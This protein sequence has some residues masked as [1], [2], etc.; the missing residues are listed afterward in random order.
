MVYKLSETTGK[1]IVKR[2]QDEKKIKFGLLFL[3]TGIIRNS[4]VHLNAIR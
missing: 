1:D 3:A 2:Q 4:K